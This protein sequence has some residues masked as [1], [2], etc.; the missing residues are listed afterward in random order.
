MKRMDAICTEI[1]SI[2]SRHSTP[3]AVFYDI[4]EMMVLSLRNGWESRDEAWEKREAQYLEIVG[5]HDPATVEYATQLLGEMILQASDGYKDMVGQLY[6]DLDISNR[7]SGQFFTPYNLSRLTARMAFDRGDFDKAIAEKGYV[8]VSEP[9]CGSGGMIV[10]M[11]DVMKSEG[12]HPS[13]HLIAVA[14]D[15]DR[16]CVNMT[17]LNC[18]IYDIPATIILG[19]T[20]AMEENMSME[21]PA[22][23]RLKREGRHS[24]HKRGT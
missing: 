11:A 4:V 8:S 5:R 20:I 7:H 15:I 17:Y 3:G 18:A 1:R 14:Q 2:A 22:L 24:R 19:D 9:T 12:Y 16:M 6:M 13:V 10:A 21:T 23:L